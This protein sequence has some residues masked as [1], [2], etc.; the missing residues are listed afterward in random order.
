MN[1]FRLIG[2]PQQLRNLMKSWLKLRSL[3]ATLTLSRISKLPLYCCSD[4]GTKTWKTKNDQDWGRQKK[5]P[6]LIAIEPANQEAIPGQTANPS[7]MEEALTGPS[8]T[9]W[10]DAVIVEY[11][12]IGIRPE[13]GPTCSSK[14]FILNVQEL[15]TTILSHL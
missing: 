4:F 7:T 5:Q 3:P 8:A 2:L 14:G 10:R 11:N 12:K 1:E 13:K 9:E 6:N 15:I